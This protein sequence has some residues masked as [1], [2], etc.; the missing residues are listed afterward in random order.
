MRT[1]RQPLENIWRDCYD[2]T[3]P[4]RGVQF[5]T[6]NLTTPQA[7]WQAAYDRQR[8]LYDTT[9]TASVRQLASSLLSG[10]TPANSQWFMQTVDGAT[11]V[12]RQWLENASYLTWKNIHAS[13]Y[14]EVA[15]EGF[16]DAVIT[17]LFAIFVR[18][19]VDRPYEFSLWELSSLYFAESRRGGGIDTAF[20]E[21]ALTRSQAEAEYGACCCKHLADKAANDD[22]LYEYVQVLMP[23]SAPDIMHPHAVAS[24]HVCKKCKEIVKTSGFHEMP[25]IVPRIMT[26]PGNVYS[27]GLVY[28]ALPTIRSLNKMQETVLGC[29]D[30]SVAGMWGAVDDGILNPKTVTV[31]PRKIIT[32]AA[33]DS[34]FPLTPNTDFQVAQWMIDNMQAAVKKIMLSDQLQAQDGPAMTATEVNARVALIRQALGPNYERLQDEFL[35]PLVTRCFNIALRAGAFGE[36][37]DSLQGRISHITYLSPLARAQQLEELMALERYE[38]SLAQMAQLGHPET[39]DWY[40]WDG[41]AQRKAQLANV[42]ATLL[43]DAGNVKQVREARQQAVEQQQQ[44]AMAMEQVKQTQA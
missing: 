31:G 32:V 3:F 40:N 26:I 22:Q 8:R 13:N 30:M 6:R 20:Y 36:M 34:F 4:L 27:H 14:P 25:L 21:F 28:E 19:G 38:G 23:N 11:T 16:I 15:F 5:Y 39:L 42:P 17:G 33:K 43:L 44:Q 29:A 24:I 12:E 2:M 10:L 7:A 18:E 1:D 41:V 35:R 9:G 37:P